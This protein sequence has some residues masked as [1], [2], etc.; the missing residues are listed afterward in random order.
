MPTPRSRCRYSRH[1]FVLTVGGPRGSGAAVKQCVSGRRRPVDSHRYLDADLGFDHLLNPR[2][3]FDGF[4]VRLQCHDQRIA[5][6]LLSNGFGGRVLISGISDTDK[7]SAVSH[8]PVGS[9]SCR[10]R[11]IPKIPRTLELQF[12]GQVIHRT[13]HLLI[14]WPCIL[15]RL[16]GVDP[17]EFLPRASAPA[18]RRRHSGLILAQ[19]RI[20]P[21]NPSARPLSKACRD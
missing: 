16:A 17:Q 8:R 6:L 20:A 11:F 12:I 19:G 21:R 9:E 2:V 3:Q 13:L 5:C 7:P 10:S 18:V 4:I 1:L 14:R 15:Q